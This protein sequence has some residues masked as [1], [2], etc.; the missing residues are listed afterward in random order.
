M[1]DPSHPHS[2]LIVSTT[3]RPPMR[4]WGWPWWSWLVLVLASVV[5]LAYEGYVLLWLSFGL[6]AEHPAPETV[7][8]VKKA[9]RGLGM[10]VL[11]PWALAS[12][13]LRRVRVLVTALVCSCPA[14]WFCWAAS[15][16]H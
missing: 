5:T 2:P 4:L 9:S 3:S 15:Q 14:I 12:L 10:T 16:T 8:A 11:V 13:A 7:A 1:Q 6:S